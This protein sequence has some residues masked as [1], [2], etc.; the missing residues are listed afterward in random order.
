MLSVAVIVPLRELFV[1][2][3]A[4][5][6]EKRPPYFDLM[7]QVLSE[8]QK[9]PERTAEYVCFSLPFLSVPNKI[10]SNRVNTVLHCNS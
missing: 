9:P 2:V 3:A 10:R 1:A 5:L 8:I 7:A 4:V 6:V